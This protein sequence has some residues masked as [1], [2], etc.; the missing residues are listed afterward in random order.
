VCMGASAWNICVCATV[1]A[2][3]AAGFVTD[4][5]NTC[6]S[7]WYV[8]VGV[9]IYIYILCL[10]C[11][12]LIESPVTILEIQYLLLFRWFLYMLMCTVM[13]IRKEKKIGKESW[14]IEWEQKVKKYMSE[15][16]SCKINIICYFYSLYMW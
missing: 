3:W 5:W 6:C 15:Y 13:V 4:Y 9:H 11:E 14:I 10:F 1:N 8:V 16:I 7:L 2:V 12:V